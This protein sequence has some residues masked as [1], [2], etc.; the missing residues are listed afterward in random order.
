MPGVDGWSVLT[1]LK[2]DGELAAI[3]VIIVTI[4]DNK[5]MG[6]TLGA[7][8][9]LTKPVDQQRLVSIIRRHCNRQ[10]RSPVL[11]IEDDDSSRQLMA[12][13]LEKEGVNVVA[14]EDAESGLALLAEQE[15]ALILLDLILPG[16]D[17]FQFIEAVHEN[18][19]WRNIPIVVVTAKDLS[20]QEHEFLN[21]SAQKIMKKGVYNRDDLLDIVRA[22][23]R[24]RVL[25]EEPAVH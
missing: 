11:I 13:M 12:G 7:A 5:D 9:Y 24:R 3:P 20:P 6:F 2:A 22:T 15:P 25:D 1:Q 19:R 21:Q 18:E 16:L 17:G 8:D 14:V 4:L 10:S 23:M